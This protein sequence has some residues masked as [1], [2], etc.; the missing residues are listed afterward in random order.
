M[1]QP[2]LTRRFSH[3]LDIALVFEVSYKLVTEL[4]VMEWTKAF[5]IGF[6]LSH[7]G[8][9]YRQ[10]SRRLRSEYSLSG[11]LRSSP[12]TASPH[13]PKRWLLPFYVS[14]F[15]GRGC[16]SFLGGELRGVSS[17]EVHVVCLLFIL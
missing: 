8:Y 12:R 11:Y 3:A 16:L 2:P 14:P 4:D 10:G 15:C 5:W 9:G 6:A 1:H 17:L 13:L 7:T